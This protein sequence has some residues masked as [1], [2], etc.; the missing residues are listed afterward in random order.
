[1][2]PPPLWGFMAYML[3]C[4]FAIGIL[5]SNFNALA[6]EPL[7][8]IAGMAAALIGSVT[9]LLAL[10]LGYVIG[11][12]YNHS[13]IP[14]VGAFAVLSAGSLL[15]IVCTGGVAPRQAQGISPG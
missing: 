10:G 6:M 15:L 13:V 3:V 4:F 14:L 2:Q 8:E 7:G 5:F 1:M 9:T 11:Q 12:L